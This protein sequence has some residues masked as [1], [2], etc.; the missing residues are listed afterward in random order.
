MAL[1][2][3]GYNHL[4]PLLLLACSHYNGVGCAT[5]FSSSL[6][7]CQD[8]CIDRNIVGFILYLKIASRELSGDATAQRELVLGELVTH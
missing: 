1:H 4:L 7:T 3:A 2:L 8:Q 5:L 6:Q